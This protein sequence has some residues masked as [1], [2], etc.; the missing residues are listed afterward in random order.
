MAWARRPCS[1]RFFDSFFK[2]KRM[3][4]DA[5][6]S[7]LHLISCSNPSKSGLSKKSLIE[8]SRP[9]QTFLMVE[10]VV[11][12]FLP[13]TMLFKVDCVT[14]QMV[15]S[16]FTVIFRSLQS[17]KILS[18]TAVPISIFITNSIELIQ[19]YRFQM[20]KFNSFKLTFKFQ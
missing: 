15:P 8:I 18:F 4:P 12:L 1:K 2:K 13:F 14:P 7:G 17:S 3:R 16:L 20:K 10:T 5:F 11:L 9:S 6:A 19:P